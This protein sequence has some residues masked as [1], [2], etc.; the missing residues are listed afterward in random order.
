MKRIIILFFAIIGSFNL[1]A[2]SAKEGVHV[3]PGAPLLHF[4]IRQI[5]SSVFN[6]GNTNP[7]KNLIVMLFNPTCGHC[8]DFTKMFIKNRKVD[9]KDFDF[10]LMT[11]DNM[12]PSLKDF[13][14]TTGLTAS[15]SMTVGVDMG[16][17]TYDLFIY[18]GLPQIMLY[19]KDKKLIKIYTRETKLE[20]I[21]ST[22]GLT[23][24]EP[25]EAKVATGTAELKQTKK[26][27]KKSKKNKIKS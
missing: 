17:T 6:T 13:Y 3:Q 10:I 21:L 8:I 5:D 18:D 4:D 25:L 20:T 9:F 23:H 11:G 2:Q 22:Y 15:D 24:Q 16:A 1:K 26:Q 7:N 12:L 19:G 14:K 27:K